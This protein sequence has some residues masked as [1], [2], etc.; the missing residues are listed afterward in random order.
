M[1][2]SFE[3][4]RWSV[5]DDGIATLVLDRPD[6]LNAFSVTMARE[7][8]EFFQVHAHSDGIRAVVVT[9]AGR[10]LAQGERV[11]SPVEGV[12]RAPGREP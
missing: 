5:D 3:T 7:L 1:T 9:G 11:V 6:Q 4:I 2:D 12:P 10:G 8:T